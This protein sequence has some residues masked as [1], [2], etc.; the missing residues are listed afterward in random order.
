MKN[1]IQTVCFLMVLCAFSWLHT[2]AFADSSVP[3]KVNA[4][5][6]IPLYLDSA[7]KNG[8][9]RYGNNVPKFILPAL[10]FYHGVQLA[11]D[12][13]MKEGIEARIEVVD[14]RRE[15]LA[16]KV[17]SEYSFYKPDLIISVVQNAT[18]LRYLSDLALQRK[19]PFVSATYPN[20]AG[21]SQN[22]SLIIVNSTLK[23]HCNSLHQYLNKTYGQEKI[24][25]FSR[26]SSP[27]DRIKGLLE[28]AVNADKPALKKNWKMVELDDSFAEEDLIAHLDST[29]TNILVG[30]SLDNAFGLK[31]IKTLSSI[32]E[33]YPSSIYGMPTW[34]DFVLTRAEYKG[35]DVFYTTPY[36]SYS[37]N[38]RI[39]QSLVQKF[40][41]I[42]NSRPS[43][44]VFKGFET[45][46]RFVKTMA[47]QKDSFM[48]NLNNQ[49]ARVFADF[50][51][52]PINHKKENTA[53]DYWE[54]TK[55]YFIKKTDGAVKSV[56]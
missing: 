29:K 26:K 31:L 15:G 45:T 32:R 24:I 7:F 28:D 52:S 3:K 5:I 14:S 46:Y 4:T 35:V 41:K 51:F 37:A 18:E 19:I 11:A 30:A 48:V 1:R 42:A 23:T 6:L 9:Y 55:V 53:P 43:D 2:S 27:G 20:D 40:K 39:Y 8:G 44:M 47:M 16:Q 21:I 22:P 49:E 38:A 56:F 25:V 12:S 36:I 54:N 13:L 10:E 33:T 34:D 17:F 50:Y